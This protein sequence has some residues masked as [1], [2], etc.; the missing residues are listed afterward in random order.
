MRKFW[1]LAAL[2]FFTFLPKTAA[3][4]VVGKANVMKSATLLAGAPLYGYPISTASFETGAYVVWR[5]NNSA[6]SQVNY[7]TTSGYGSSSTTVCNN[8]LAYNAYAFYHCIV[9]TGLSQST[10]YHFQIVSTNALGTTFSSSDQT[11]TTLASPTGTVKKVKSS[12]GDYTS[13][14]ACIAAASPGWTCEVYAGGA[15][16]TTTI[17]VGVSGSSGSPITVL[18]HDAV[19]VP[20][21]HITSSNSYITIQGF[22]MSTAAYS[23]LQTCS[24]HDCIQ[25]GNNSNNLIIQNNYLHNIYDGGFIVRDSSTYVTA[26][27]VISNNIMAWTITTNQNPPYTYPCTASCA[28]KCSS[29]MHGIILTA[30][31]SLFD[32]NDFQEADH[33]M[34][35]EGNKM[36]V[37]RNIFH[38]TK[39]AD[40]GV[41][42]TSAHNDFLSTV[43]GSY[44][45]T[46]QS[47]HHVYEANLDI[48]RDD[49]NV[50]TILGESYPSQMSQLLGT[51]DGSTKTFSGTLSLGSDVSIAPFGVA[52][53]VCT[54]STCSSGYGSA[55]VIDNAWGA[56]NGGGTGT[57]NYTSGAISVT[58][59]SA[60][61]T[62]APV[63]AFY[64]LTS[65]SSHDAIVRFN[66]SYNVGSAFLSSGQGG[67]TG[68][69]FYNNTIVHVGYQGGGSNTGGG[70]I[71][72][73][74]GGYNT[75][76]NWA[77]V[78]NLFYDG[79]LYTNGPPWTVVPGVASSG[80]YWSPWEYQPGYSLVFTSACDPS[81]G[82]S[83]TS[84]TTSAPGMVL[85]RNPL[86][87]NASNYNFN[88]QAGSPALHAGTYLTTVASTDSGSGTSL[89]LN[90]AGFFQDGYG[91][92]GVSADCIAVT[93]VTNTVCI[94]AANY[95]TNTLTLASGVTRSVGDKV[96][97]YSDSTGTIRLT[98]AAPNIGAW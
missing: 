59:T 17:T 66:T 11:F 69:R 97:L 79:W 29:G 58:F 92:P 89:V 5:T 60:P 2:L 55:S 20:G 37:R 74:S 54:P 48:N 13:V 93:T 78:N 63:E 72:P 16:D 85:G 53:M 7:G 91:I 1:V 95:A 8:S 47:I 71:V 83:Y 30:N 76:S 90:D 23:A 22:E 21:L 35:S 67:F 31:T 15:S 36:I 24:E 26:N 98:G 94:T 14:G 51:G 38:D 50:H 39:E 62:N 44:T 68:G 61:P 41:S 12:G 80:A 10:T 43:G 84:A 73:Y 3:Q 25:V 86:F 81:P 82:C 46:S 6:T 9:V 96:W 33:L 57:V 70:A 88:L 52:I 49:T 28:P 32:S 19:E 87:V 4:L 77:A 40:M 45:S 64:N 42:A 75:E 56:L 65:Y 18:A 34:Q 27:D